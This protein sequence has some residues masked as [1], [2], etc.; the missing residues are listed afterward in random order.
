ML[1]AF[2]MSLV[3]LVVIR[4]VFEINAET[5]IKNSLSLSPFAHIRNTLTMPGRGKRGNGRGRG[6]GGAGARGRG[7]GRG[8]IGGGGRGR[9]RELIPSA[10]GYVYRP[11]SNVDEFDDDFRIYGQFGSDQDD[12]E[13][14][15]VPHAKSKAVI[16]CIHT[17]VW[18]I[19]WW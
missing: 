4:H 12:S 14:E 3:L 1:L 8:S 5:L 18:L 9:N 11:R 10:I 17:S 6:R 2:K 19:Q 16:Q 15:F 13:S 7:R